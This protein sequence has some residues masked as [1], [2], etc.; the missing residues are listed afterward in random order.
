MSFKCACCGNMI[1]NE[2]QVL[3]PNV[4]RKVTYHQNYRKFKSDDLEF[5]KNTDGWE[6]SQELPIA[7]S[8]AQKFLETHEPTYTKKGK[9]VINVMRRPRYEYTRN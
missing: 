9:E 5:V 6:I 3:V 4:I 8:H 1:K 2:K 7:E